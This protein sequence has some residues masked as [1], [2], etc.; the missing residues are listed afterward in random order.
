MS[1][2]RLFRVNRIPR[3][4]QAGRAN[5]VAVRRAARRVLV[6]RFRRVVVPLVVQQV[7]GV[8]GVVLLVRAALH[9]RA[10]VVARHLPNLVFQ[11][12][13]ANQAG[14]VRVPRVVVPAARRLRV[15]R[16]VVVRCRPNPASRASRVKAVNRAVASRAA[17]PVV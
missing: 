2:L 10:V 5:R 11:A 4:S 17:V 8:V 3:V 7:V 6:V 9:G 12:G 13:R 16:Q 15:V 14:R 1:R